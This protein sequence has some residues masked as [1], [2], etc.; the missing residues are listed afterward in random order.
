M[1]GIIKSSARNG[2][3]VVTYYALKTLQKCQKQN[4]SILKL[5]IIK[6]P[7]KM[8]VHVGTYYVLC[9]KR[10]RRY[11]KSRY[12]QESC[13][14]WCTNKYLLYSPTPLKKAMNKT[15]DILK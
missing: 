8:Y 9:Q 15:S 13:K 1:R 4:K 3:H 11:D 6:S 10:F 14:D 7:A 12:Y 2:V 5:C